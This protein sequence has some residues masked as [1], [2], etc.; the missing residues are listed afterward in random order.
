MRNL[1]EFARERARRFGDK[2]LFLC[3]ET[4]VSYRAYDEH[5]DRLACGL[6]ELGLAPGDRV[7]VLLPNGLEI[8]ETYTAAA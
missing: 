8:V 4:A 7:A 5:T 2:T 1:G 6:G 3:D